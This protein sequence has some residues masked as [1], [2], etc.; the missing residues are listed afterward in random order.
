MTYGPGQDERKLIPYV[1][2]SLLKGEAPKLASGR[3]EIDW[4]YID[5]VMDGFLAATH[6]PDIEGHTID[7][8]SGL[9]VPIRTVVGEI[10]KLMD[11]EVAPLFNALPDRP[12]EPV[13]VADM[14]AAHA[15]LGWGPKTPLKSG[16]A[17]TIE[18]YR[19]QLQSTSPNRESGAALERV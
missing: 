5:D 17:H 10:V 3:Q 4:I 16:L 14:G 19:A 2:L 9:L 15:K 8:G 1:V 12:V 7:L 11:T 6:A 13:R 18:W